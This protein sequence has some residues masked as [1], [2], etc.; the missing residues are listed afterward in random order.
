MTLR[1]AWAAIAIATALSAGCKGDTI[2][3]PDPKGKDIVA[4][5]V[6][7]AATSAEPTPGLRIYKVL[8]VDDYPEPIGYNY[9]LAAYD[10]KAK[11]F[12]EARE[13]RRRGKMKVVLGHLEVRAV[14]F[15]KR[16]HR[17]IAK[18]PLT[19]AELA[20]YEKA[21]TSR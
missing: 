10:P 16:D 19:E 15:L 13:I 4:G 14:D 12:E 20:P 8:H 18:E 11:T 2:P 9:H 1:T 6:V 17:V 3:P 21:R 7:A 5:A